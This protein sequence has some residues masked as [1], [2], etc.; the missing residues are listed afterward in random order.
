M[1][2]FYKQRLKRMQK[3]L[4][5]NLYNVNLILSDGAY[6]YDIARA[7]TYLLDDLDNQSD[8]KQD[9]KE[10]ETEAYHLAERK[11]LIHE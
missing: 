4:A 11:K 2:E 6:D 9:A 10:V 1:N 3:V 7:M 8:F 5:R